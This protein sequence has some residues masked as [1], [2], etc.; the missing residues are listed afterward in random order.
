MPTTS[1]IGD[2]HFLMECLRCH[3]AM[4]ARREWVGHQVQCPYC[5]S[6]M[7]VPEPQPGAA[8]VRAEGP[9]VS[10]KRVFNF[11]CPRCGSL[12]QAHTG[13]IRQ[14]ATCPTCGARF[15]V[16]AVRGRRGMPEPAP[17]LEA[18]PD[19][20]TPLHA[21]AASGEQAPR[22]IR[23]ADGTMAIE[24]PR[25]RAFNPV[26]ADECRECATPFTMDT[27]STLEDVQ[28]EQRSLAA[29]TLGFVA[30][31]LFPLLVPGLVALGLG[32]ATMLTPR[33]GRFPVKAAV[34][35][36]MAFVSLAGGVMFWLLR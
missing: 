23:R 14:S 25:C 32:F 20:P 15:V 10:P 4:R 17:L 2:S 24:C 22:L 30:L 6:Y 9:D 34:G 18:P 35:T 31:L 1:A 7:R 29:L 8:P 36:A 28:S 26:D 3:R 27:A 19:A 11:P 21:Y 5:A 16:P 12:L 13:M 33:Q